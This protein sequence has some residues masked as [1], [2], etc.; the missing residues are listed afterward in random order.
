ME[1]TIKVIDYFELDCEEC[2]GLNESNHGKWENN[3]S[4]GKI[5]KQDFIICSEC[6]IYGLE[7]KVNFILS[8]TP[9]E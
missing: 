8:G 9:Q 5:K 3:E 2:F 1:E 7:K 4:N 6:L